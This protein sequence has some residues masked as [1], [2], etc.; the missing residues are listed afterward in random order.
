[1]RWLIAAATAAV[2]AS[3]MFYAAYWHWRNH[4]FDAMILDAARE[5]DLPPALLRAVIRHESGFNHRSIGRAGEIGLMQVTPAAAADW[6]AGTG[7]SNFSKYELF[8]PEINIQAGAWYL[9]RARNYWSAKANPLPYALAEYNAGRSNALRWAKNDRNDPN[10]F[11]HNITYP[12]T[13][14]YI[15]DIM[16]DYRRHNPPAATPPATARRGGKKE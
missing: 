4:A 12:L 14:R 11:W 6:A 16:Q 7:R 10:V 13:R 15:R 9:S 3:A 5:H 1:M 8:Q 2:I